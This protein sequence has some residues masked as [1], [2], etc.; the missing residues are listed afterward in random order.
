[1]GMVWRLSVSSV[2]TLHLQDAFTFAVCCSLMPL[3]TLTRTRCRTPPHSAS[4]SFSSSLAPSFLTYIPPHTYIFDIHTLPPP[5]SCLAFTLSFPILHHV[6]AHSFAQSPTHTLPSPSFP[7]TN[8]FPLS[9]HHSPPPLTLPSLSLFHFHSLSLTH[10][11][12][13]LFSSTLYHPY[14]LSALQS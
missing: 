1:M 14:T 10:T 11:P 2:F 4:P 9:Y 7:C 6:L 12:L 8:I 13:P 3:R 5:E